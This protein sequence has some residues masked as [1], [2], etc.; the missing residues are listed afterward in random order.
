MKA[1]SFS[2]RL[3]SAELEIMLR[4]A[5][6][7][8]KRAL[9]SS[10]CLSVAFGLVVSRVSFFDIAIIGPYVAFIV[11]STLL[12]TFSNSLWR[13][14]ASRIV[15]PLVGRS[16]GQTSFLSGWEAFDFEDWLK[17]NLGASQSRSTS[18]QTEGVYRGTSYRLLEQA[19]RQP[20]LNSSRTAEAPSYH[21]LIEISVP[22]RFSGRVDIIRR[23]A[24][25]DFLDSFKKHFPGTPCQVASGNTLFDQA[26]A[27]HVK[28][29]D[30]HS[31]LLS[32]LV[33]RGLLAITRE[34]ASSKLKVWFENG[35]F[36]LEYPLENETFQNIS[37]LTPMPSLSGSAA[38]ICWNL[39]IAQRLIDCF[40]GDYDGPLR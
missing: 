28:D 17:D 39:T 22:L 9:S 10:I 32:P 18:W 38:T 26:F 34:N 31:T 24:T 27:I 7:Q 20:R 15:A 2:P 37:L 1:V 16:Y 33:M 23:T 35:W 36:N 21:Y 40:K 13:R 12:W 19:V 11:V 4:E 3:D 5:E 14:V 6:P 29:C 30:D 8:R 25:T